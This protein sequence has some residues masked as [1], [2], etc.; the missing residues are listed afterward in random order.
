[1]KFTINAGL[2]KYGKVFPQSI[3]S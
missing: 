3:T 1:M 2:F